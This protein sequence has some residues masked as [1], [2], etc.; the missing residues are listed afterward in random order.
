[1]VSFS[2][3]LVVERE[4]QMFDI[5]DYLRENLTS[6]GVLAFIFGAG[7]IT[8]FGVIG[9]AWKVM[10]TEIHNLPMQIRHKRMLLLW[11]F[12]KPTMEMTKASD[13]IATETETRIDYKMSVKVKLTSQ[14]DER[15]WV[16]LGFEIQAWQRGFGRLSLRPEQSKQIALHGKGDTSEVTFNTVASYAKDNSFKVAPLNMKEKYEFRVLGIRGG[17]EAFLNLSDN[18]RVRKITPKLKA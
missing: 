14:Y 18:L 5:F 15:T 3:L 1:M 11:F 9:K 13:L 2:A 17:L 10:K 12:K 4:S 6:K 8:W 16:S 7:L